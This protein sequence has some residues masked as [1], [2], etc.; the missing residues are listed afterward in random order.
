MDCLA[1]L[2]CYDHAMQCHES[3][4]NICNIGVKE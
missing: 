4:L 1:Q 2:Q 3:V